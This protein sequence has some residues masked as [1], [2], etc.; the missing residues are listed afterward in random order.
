MKKFASMLALAFVLAGLSFSGASA[1]PAGQLPETVRSLMGAA[2][3]LEAVQHRRWHHRRWRH[4]RC[5]RVC[6][7]HRGHRHCRIVCRRRW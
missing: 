5:Y 3:P 7:W 2:S 4:R 1:A 6:R